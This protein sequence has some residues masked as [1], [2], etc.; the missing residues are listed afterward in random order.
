MLVLDGL[1]QNR[2]SMRM[3][4]S[5]GSAFVVQAEEKTYS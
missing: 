4:Y 5:V 1:M 2:M 3:L